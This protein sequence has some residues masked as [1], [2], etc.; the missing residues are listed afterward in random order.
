MNN[1][2]KMILVINQIHPEDEDRL[3]VE[4][5]MRKSPSERL[6]EAYR[7]LRNYYMSLNGSYPDKFERVITQR[8]L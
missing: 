6:A 1:P 2:R 3:D 7:L 4:Y 8:K 5:W